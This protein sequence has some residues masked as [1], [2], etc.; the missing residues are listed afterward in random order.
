MAGTGGKRKAA[1][2]KQTSVSKRSLSVAEKIAKANGLSFDT[3]AA[4]RFPLDVMLQAMHEVYASMGAVAAFNLAK[5]C[6]PYL[7][8]RLNAVDARIQAGLTVTVV[9]YGDLPDGNADPSDARQ[10]AGQGIRGAIAGQVSDAGCEPRRECEGASPSG[11]EP[12][13]AVVG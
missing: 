7:H 8:P 4:K 5:E 1:G 10:I 9:K 11:T 2:R 6:A 12:R 13:G 3:A